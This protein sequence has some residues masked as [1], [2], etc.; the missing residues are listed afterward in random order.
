MG[1][2]S[3]RV[4]FLSLFAL[5]AIIAIQST[6]GALPVYSRQ[7]NVSCATCHLT[8]PRLNKFGLAFQANFYN[9]PGETRVARR[10]PTQY[11]PISTITTFSYDH[12]QTQRQ[13]TAN[14]RSFEIFASSGLDIGKA[15]Q[16][17]FFLDL[18]AA[19][20]NSA[21]TEGDLNDA[22]V[23]VPLLGRRGQLAVTVGQ[24]SPLRFQYDPNN[25]L[26]DTLPFGLTEGSD[27]FA[28]GA[29]APAIRLDYFDNRAKSSPDG[30]YL[31]LAVPFRGHLEFTRQGTVR[32]SSGVYAH[33]FHRW[34]YASAGVI[35]YLHKDAHQIGL[36]GTYAIRSRLFLTTLAVLAHAPGLNTVHLSVEPEYL[37][38]RNLSVTARAELISGD[39]SE[40]STDAAINYYPTK[41]QFIRLTAEAVQRRQ[42][43]DLRATLRVQY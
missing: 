26:A 24:I 11:L 18:L 41:N 32:A 2:C 12:D 22:Y 16:G 39:L 19:T 5:F 6:A 20:T 4:R 34:G 17:G 42:A 28:F 38:H 33:F 7:Y 23:S 21:A 3:M 27:D 29:S 25:T 31:T 9:W 36:V 35:G 43:R 8:V 37:F 1:V 14:F 13:E 15:H 40:V 10:D 30:N